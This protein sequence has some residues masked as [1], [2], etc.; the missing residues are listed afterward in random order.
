MSSRAENVA[1]LLEIDI[2]NGD[3]CSEVESG[4]FINS[5]TSASLLHGFSEFQ[6]WTGSSSRP[7]SDQNNTDYVSKRPR[8]CFNNDTTPSP[9][10]YPQN[11]PGCESG[12]RVIL[13]ELQGRDHRVP[14]SSI[15]DCLLVELYD[16]YSSARISVD[17]PDS[18]TE[19]SSSELFCRSNTGSSFLQELQEKHTRRHQ[20]SYLSQKG[21]FNLY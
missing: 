14:R 7:S 15:V 1:E 2:C 10:L 9:S 21:Q 17:S 13:G 20:V 6:Q 11:G 4:L 12:D 3:V 8:D 18:S 5:G 19:A 16:T